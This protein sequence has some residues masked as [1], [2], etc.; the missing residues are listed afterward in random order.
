MKDTCKITNGRQAEEYE[1]KSRW[2]Y[3]EVALWSV[4]P[5][6]HVSGYV[7]LLLFHLI[8]GVIAPRQQLGHDLLVH[9]ALYWSG[10]CTYPKAKRQRQEECQVGYHTPCI[11]QQFWLF[12][13]VLKGQDPTVKVIGSIVNLRIV[14]E[15]F[16]IPSSANQDET[17]NASGAL[18]LKGSF[19]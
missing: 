14:V 19:A 3:Y 17:T 9:S 15:F 12:V 6:R 2:Y 13:N 8:N 5:A 10:N 11:R 16:L 7:C 4:Y 18:D 1:F